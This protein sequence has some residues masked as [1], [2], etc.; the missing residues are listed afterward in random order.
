MDLRQVESV[1]ILDDDSS[2]RELLAAILESAGY[3]VRVAV[4]GEEAVALAQ[5]MTPDV[6]ILDIQLPGLSGYEVL[7]RLRQLFGLQI[8]IMFLTASRVTAIDRAEGLE[9]GADDYLLKPFD[10]S[11]LLARVRALLRRAQTPQQSGA[12]SLT[13]REIEVLNLLGQGHSPGEVA[14]RLFIAPGTVSKHVER[15]LRKLDVHSQAQ[16][17]ARAYR[18]GLIYPGSGAFQQR[19]AR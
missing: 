4:D 10:P 16:A 12:S 19:A 14:V 17:V 11:E 5:E 3:E 15:I 7:R 18:E 8:M 2:I 1:L 13:P 9:M 6:A